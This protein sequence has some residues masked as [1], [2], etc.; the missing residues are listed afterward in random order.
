MKVVVLNPFS[1]GKS[2][3]SAYALAPKMPKGFKFIQ[4]ESTNSCVD[5]KMAERMPP[6]YVNKVSDALVEDGDVLVDLGTTGYGKFMK[7][8]SEDDMIAFFVDKWVL[9]TT[10]DP[11]FQ[12]DTAKCVK[13]LLA[14]GVE[15][16]NIIVL[17]NQVKDEHN[18]VANIPELFSYLFG[19]LIKLGVKVP[20]VYLPHTDLFSKLKQSGLTVD[21]V[22][23]KRLQFEKD[24]KKKGLFSGMSK[25]DKKIM[26]EQLR[27]GSM[28][29]HMAPYINN[30]ASVVMS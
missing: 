30:V 19:E 16:E 14:A 11:K 7:V 12:E 26:T 20:N 21:E 2:V 15:K 25:D 3:V 17:P 29:G 5:V 24:K 10:S 13:E 9:P 28:A 27:M 4:V 6:S 1:A 23:S 18:D 8:L 22:L